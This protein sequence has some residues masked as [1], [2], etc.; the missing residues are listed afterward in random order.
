LKEE[1]AGED[2]KQKAA[3]LTL[4]EKFLSLRPM[5]EEKDLTMDHEYDGIR[6]L[7]NPTPPWFNFLFYG[8]ILI[9]IVYMVY[10]HVIGDGQVM[11]NE[12]QAELAIWETK[13]VAYKATQT[14]LIDESN[15]KLISD[16]ALLASA[17]TIFKSKCAACH[18]DLGEGKNGPNLTDDYAIHGGSLSDLF[19]TITV[20]V[21]EKGMIP[22]KGLLKPEEIQNMASY[23]LSIKGTLPE[24][25]GKAPEGDKIK[26]EA[27][28][29]V[30]ANADLPSESE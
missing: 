21:S 16:P 12:Y 17:A 4:W 30:T 24:G 13:A 10:Y 26:A 2:T 14:D 28:V 7:D 3:E 11:E 5:A 27:A 20:G 8:T 1:K 6:E 22:W 23:I 25:V 15:V 29:E 19:R 18:G 9:G